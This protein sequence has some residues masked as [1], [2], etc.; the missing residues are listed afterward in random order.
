MIGTKSSTLC[1]R[2]GF[3]ML[4]TLFVVMLL[5][6]IGLLLLTDAQDAA[7][8]TL[9]TEQK[10][11]SL[12]AAEAGLDTAIDLLDR[13]PT[14]ADN[15]TVSGQTVTLGYR[16]TYTVVLNNFSG[17]AVRYATDTNSGT[18][19]QV[20]VQPGQ[21]FVVS[22]GTGLMASR[23]S[24]VEA[25]LNKPNGGSV[26]FPN[27]AIEAG[28]DIDGNWNSGACA[29]VYGSAP[30]VNDANIHANG[31]IPANICFVDGQATAS[32]TVSGKTNATKGQNGGTPQITLPTSQMDGF[33]SYEKGIAQQGGPYN[34]YIPNGGS[35]PSNFTC[36]LGAPPSGCVVFLD[37][38]IHLS[39]Q[40]SA[41]FI[42]KVTVVINGDLQETG[43][44]S[45]TFQ[46]NSGSLLAVAGNA[47]VGGN[48][49]TGALLWAKG[50]TTLHGN[51][52][53]QGAL[54]AGGN[55]SLLGGGTN[56]GFYYNPGAI[57]PPVNV[58]GAVVLVAYGE[59]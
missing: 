59:Y 27:G 9:N 12:N 37:G 41:N 18:S 1:R 54:I 16:Y 28:G 8:G 29:A 6:F 26:N 24:K 34:L 38:S 22:T 17:N 58:P 56:G 10:N 45:I 36:G 55:V 46:L 35:L 48:A 30:G 11:Q 2:R 20:P 49:Y 5:V 40:Q 33:V 13:V 32:G 14:T 53:Q 25:I 15:T 57:P 43:K 47:D 51:G 23:S 4:L 44:S 7:S 39:G 21:A 50:D 19:Q 3:A 31:N 52:A 42:G